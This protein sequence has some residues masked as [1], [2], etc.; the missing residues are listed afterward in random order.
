MMPKG[1]GKAKNEM[2]TE[3][4]FV[5]KHHPLSYNTTTT[6]Q[7]GEHNSSTIVLRH[8]FHFSVHTLTKS[9][10]LAY[11]TILAWFK[12]MCSVNIWMALIF[13]HWSLPEKKHSNK[14]RFVYND[15]LA[16]TPLGCWT[17]RLRVESIA[18]PTSLR[19]FSHTLRD[20]SSLYSESLSAFIGGS[21]SSNIFSKAWKWSTGTYID[22]SAKPS[23]QWKCINKYIV[24]IIFYMHTPINRSHCSVTLCHE[25]HWLYQ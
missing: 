22:K 10:C 23:M 14:I 17:G 15:Y 2:D 13:C 19:L 24:C 6:S 3:Q 7:E 11:T 16:L 8:C 21:S 9:S 20:S 18:F 12:R 25:F 5:V 4:L 1:K